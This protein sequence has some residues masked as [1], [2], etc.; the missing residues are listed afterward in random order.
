MVYNFL[1]NYKNIPFFN[2]YTMDIYT[3]ERLKKIIEILN[4]KERISVHELASTFNV[5]EVTIRRD[6]KV[7]KDK[8]EL[9]RTH[10]GAIKK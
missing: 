9:V 4:K 10:G 1:Q 3:E 5:S 6:L 2:N 7:L 8:K